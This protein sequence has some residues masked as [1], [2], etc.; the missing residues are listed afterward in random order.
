MQSSRLADV[1]VCAPSRSIESPRENKT[2]SA[3]KPPDMLAGVVVT[4]E[5]QFVAAS[6]AKRKLTERFEELQQCK[7]FMTDEEY[8]AKRAELMD[9]I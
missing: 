8:A 1:N 4:L 6:G 3:E 9:E 2:T 7:R 5:G